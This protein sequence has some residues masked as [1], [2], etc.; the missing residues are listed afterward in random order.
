MS[1]PTS[2]ALTITNPLIAYRTLLALNKLDPD[3]AQHRLALHLQTLYHRLKDYE[4]ELEYAARL[5]QIARVVGATKNNAGSSAGAGSNAGTAAQS[6][7]SGKGGGILSSLWRGNGSENSGIETQI[8]SL[9]RSL[10]PLD[11]ALTINSPRGLLLHGE[12][13]RGKSMLL[14]LLSSSLPTR[15]KR[16]YHFSNFMLDILRRFELIRTNKVLSTPGF[17]GAIQEYSVLVLAR[18][19]IAE[20]PILFLDEFQ[21]PDRAASRIVSSLFVAFFHLGGVLIATSNRMPEELA[22]AAGVEFVPREKREAESAL[23]RILRGRRGGMSGSGRSEGMFSSA[24]DFTAF[25]EVLKTRCEIWEMEG[26]KDWRRGGEVKEEA[27][28]A[29]KTGAN[30]TSDKVLTDTASLSTK[31]PLHYHLI[32]SS[33]SPADDSFSQEVASLFAS[34]NNISSSIPWAPTTLKVYNR[35]LYLPETHA[36]VLKID[37]SSLCSAALG[38]ADY[39][40]LASTFHTLIID[41]VPVLT[42]TL[43]NEAR[44]F[45]T[46]LDALYE[47]RCR[48]LIRAEAGPDDLFFP[49]LKGASTSATSTSTNSGSATTKDSTS[50]STTT[51]EDSILSEQFSEMYQDMTSPFRPNISLYNDSTSASTSPP[52]RHIPN[53]FSASEDSDFG[54]LNAGTTTNMD[55]H[56]LSTGRKGPDFTNTSQYTGQDEQ[57]A[58]KRARSRIWEMCGRKWW[59]LGSIEDEAG[60]ETSTGFHRW[61]PLRKEERPWEESLVTTP[62]TTTTATQAPVAIGTGEPTPFSPFRTHPSPPPKFSEVHAWGVMKWGKKA[63]DWGLGVEGAKGKAKVEGDAV[64]GKNQSLGKE[65]K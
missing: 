31:T 9:T 21:L 54:P 2:R 62:V 27:L 17:G 23:M 44:R 43:K 28:I 1:A 6:N 47:A 14:D 65:G 22:K 60:G 5:D 48:V 29:L 12:V 10:S 45:I 57:F 49:D 11:S 58:Y 4:P 55:P 32:S 61:R 51:E 42:Q 56:S 30:E 41:E 3:P 33:T 24:S 16:R 40:T 38:P 15:K 7:T 53:S 20:S 25:L 37:F 36:G 35:P 34:S 8:L 26:E 59:D 39:I 19:L 50:S 18:E 13:G 52:P 64:Q 63:G 46:C